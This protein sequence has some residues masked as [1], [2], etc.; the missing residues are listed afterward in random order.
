[1]KHARLRAALKVVAGLLLVT[2]FICG[3][4]VILQRDYGNATLETA[5]DRDIESSDAVHSLVSDEFCREDFESIGTGTLRS[6][7]YYALQRQLNKLRQMNS[8]RY[9]YTAKRGKDGRLV[10]LVD[11]LDLD[12][13]DFADP[14]S[15][16]EDE[17]VPYIEKALGGET[18]YSQNIVDTTWGH[19]FTACYPVRDQNGSGEVLGALCIEMD[20]EETYGYIEKSNRRAART[21]AIAIVLMAVLGLV[22]YDFL[23]KQKQMEARQQEALEQAARAADAANRAKSTFLFNMSHDIRTPMNAILGYAS[24]AGR[25]EGISGKTRDY[26]DK[27]DLCGKKML[28]IIDN[29]LELSRIESGRVAL[30]ETVVQAGSIFDA[31]LVMVREEAEKR[32]QEL[33]ISKEILHPY[34]YMD[35]AKV[36]EII[37]NLVSNAI[38]YTGD[39]GTIRCSIRQCEDGREGWVVQE[40]R[41]EDNGIGMS[42]E[43][44]QHIYE[45]FAR[46]RSSTLSGVDGTG[47]GMGIVKKLVDMMDG[48][49]ELKSELNEGTS[50]LL[51]IPCRIAS[52]PEQTVSGQ[53]QGAPQNLLEQSR[54]AVRGKRILLA[55]DNELNAE[56]AIELLQDIGLSLEWAGDGEQ[57]IRML[58][59]QQ[60]GYYDMILMDVQMPQMDGYTA[61]RKI[62]ELGAE[63]PIVAMTANAFAEDRRKCLEAGMDDYLSK[64]LKV[65]RVVE[66]LVQYCVNKGENNER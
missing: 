19:I 61:T 41:V 30:E 9:L 14:G 55:E 28:G 4:T 5:V 23:R 66:M 58:E 39:G 42:A 6:S 65:D 48:E 29:I 52:D 60:A 20:M 32:H 38:K 27:I 24:L 21:A 1:M 31:C 49:I 59:A 63:I 50:F 13:G 62:R 37:L 2:L 15:Y 54:E 53:E 34:L 47:L 18:V 44:Q 12:A 57:C 36:T 40:L 17:M 33:T 10:Y 16:I 51:R 8:A 22:V 7:R 45:S 46:E 3:Y 11:G 56:I 35:E 64:P 25:D 43:F 26:L